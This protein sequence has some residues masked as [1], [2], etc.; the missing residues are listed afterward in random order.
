MA[1]ETPANITRAAEGFDEIEV[2]HAGKRCAVAWAPW[3]GDWFV[4]SSPR[5]GNSNAEGQWDHWID[6]AIGV[7][8]DPLTAL[9]RPE[10]H[11]AV[12]RLITND[13]YTETNRD[14]TDDELNARFGEDAA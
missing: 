10:A 6:L 7:L 9:V 3:M 8:K 13:F 11:E 5:N 14:L 12:R 1:T 4:S 2:V